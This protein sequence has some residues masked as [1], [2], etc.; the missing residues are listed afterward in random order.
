M[1]SNSITF[2]DL[3]PSELIFQILSE[4]SSKD[5]KNF[6]LS[7]KSFRAKSLP[8]L[9]RYLRLTLDHTELT[10][11]FSAFKDGGS[12]ANVRLDVRQLTLFPATDNT[13]AIIS[14]YQ[15]FTTWAH[16]F[17]S[18]RN[19]H[20]EI[21]AS[22]SF[23]QLYRDFYRRIVYIIFRS[24]EKDSLAY[25]TI[26]EVSLKIRTLPSGTALHLANLNKDLLHKENREFLEHPAFRDPFP[27]TP[28][29]GVYF[30]P[31]LETL[32]FE[33]SPIEILPTP[34]YPLSSVLTAKDTLKTVHLNI[35]QL[36]GNRMIDEYSF[37]DAEFPNV[38]TLGIHPHF[39]YDGAK[40]FFPLVKSFPNVENLMIYIDGRM[41]SG[42]RL[43]HAE[44]YN[45]V[46]LFPKLKY[47]RTFW[48][49]Q[50]DFVD[51]AQFM[52]PW[53]LE[54]DA[55]V[56]GWATNARMLEEVVFA[57]TVE[58]WRRDGTD[59]LEAIKVTVKWVDGA[60]GPEVRCYW[61]D[62]YKTERLCFDMD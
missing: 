62:E 1:S 26:K 32:Y 10:T 23:V 29:T 51:E 24:L 48:S 40:L 21:T 61:S 25:Y 28:L 11:A 53:Q 45:S 41:S 27:I 16:L 39:L 37:P 36:D 12:L 38:K 20:L 35:V 8:I 56:K 2:V 15:V 60:G 55:V 34:L 19:L 33:Y 5:L 3:I 52:S 59:R 57:R 42:N 13:N 47:L 4:L 6:S 49:E 54:T 43:I 7:S 30:P 46:S 50:Y 58:Y 9:F 31:N 17:N 44:P 18:L 22:P 14:S